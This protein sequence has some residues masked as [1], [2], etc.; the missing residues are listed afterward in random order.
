MIY[1]L[2]HGKTS[3]AN[4]A[5][6]FE[7]SVRTIQRDIEAL[8][9]AGI[10]VTAETGTK[11]GY[12][13]TDTFRMDRQTATDEDYSRILTALKG[14]SSA[15]NDTEVNTTMEKVSAL[16]QHPNTNIILDFS[17][18]REGDAA[19]LR[20]LQEAINQKHPIHFTYTNARNVSADHYV[21][22]VAVVYR[23][24]A[25]YLLAYSIAKKDYR[26]YKLVRIRDARIVENTF[27]KEHA[28]AETILR[29][30]D[31]L[32]SQECIEIDI[33]CTSAARAM[34]LEYL[35]GTITREYDNGDC[36]MT[37]HVIESEHLWFGTLLALGNTVEI[38]APERIKLRIIKAAR[39]ILALYQNCDITLS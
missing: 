1:L 38:I 10:P 6:K 3:A 22:P 7:V 19:L 18:L 5:E 23:W 31:T 15:I 20:L 32:N 17:V 12:Y 4:L 27:T 33:R 2:N 34:A 16:T 39:E 24:Y 28:D 37:L 14:F 30:K 8:C 26:L 29:Q 35:N 13:L 25:W 9:Q 11:G 36:D 21:E